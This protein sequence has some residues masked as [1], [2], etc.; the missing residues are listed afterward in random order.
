VPC[1][2]CEGKGKIPDDTTGVICPECNGK[3]YFPIERIKINNIS[4][5][6]WGEKK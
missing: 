2:Q 1:R 6:I 3:G 5:I 4:S